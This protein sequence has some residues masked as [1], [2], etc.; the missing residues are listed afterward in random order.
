MVVVVVGGG[1]S[2]SEDME[3]CRGV[4]VLCCQSEARSHNTDRLRQAA[5]FDF[6]FLKCI[7]ESVSFQLFNLKYDHLT[8]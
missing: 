4:D 5:I 6:F 2:T 3:R 7:K 1:R 8:V